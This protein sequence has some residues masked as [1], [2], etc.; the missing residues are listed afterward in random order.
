MEPEHAVAE[1]AAAGP[2]PAFNLLG[3]NLDLND[4]AFWAFVGLIIFIECDHRDSQVNHARQL[5]YRVP[6]FL[7]ATL[8]F[9]IDDDRQFTACRLTNIDLRYHAQSFNSLGVLGEARVNVLQL[10]LA[11]AR[12][13]P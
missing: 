3:W 7:I 13:Q 4:P 12:E 1:H 10:N 2:L 11:L 5:L 6:D 8:R 9:R